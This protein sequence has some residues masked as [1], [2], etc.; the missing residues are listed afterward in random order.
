MEKCLE[1]YNF[2]FSAMP[3]HITY[4]LVDAKPKFFN[5]QTICILHFIQYFHLKALYKRP[6]RFILLVNE[7]TMNLNNKTGNFHARTLF[8]GE[9]VF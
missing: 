8:S 3:I 9:T 5:I 1:R 7:Y 6:N 2:P 4:R